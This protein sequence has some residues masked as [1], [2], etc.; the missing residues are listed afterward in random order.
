MKLPTHHGLARVPYSLEAVIDAM[1]SFD[2]AAGFRCYER[3]ETKLGFKR[4]SVFSDTCLVEI[5][6]L[7]DDADYTAISTSIFF[8]RIRHPFSSAQHP[9]R[10]SMST[11]FE[12]G[13]AVT[14]HLAGLLGFVQT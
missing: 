7:P 5:H 3:A 8:N 14:S 6:G 13:R 2:G 4:H 12:F 11:S 9:S 1:V 10:A